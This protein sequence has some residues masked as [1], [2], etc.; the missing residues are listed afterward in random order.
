MV[1][2]WT[3]VRSSH[4]Q[5]HLQLMPHLHAQLCLVKA[6]QHVD[7]VK[8]RGRFILLM[9][10]SNEC[11]QGLQRSEK[12]FFYKREVSKG[13]GHWI[14]RLTLQPQNLLLTQ[15]TFNCSITLS[16]KTALLCTKSRNSKR[17]SNW[18][19]CHPLFF[20][21]VFSPSSSFQKLHCRQRLESEFKN[22]N[23]FWVWVM[24][25]VELSFI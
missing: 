18:N 1:Y 12:E 6:H 23:S 11:T 7:N 19:Y 20:F 17:N 5:A 25:L 22:K 21:A 24:G 8:P 4:P 2:P 16:S 15:L 9:D 3:A 14:C 13:E 10:S